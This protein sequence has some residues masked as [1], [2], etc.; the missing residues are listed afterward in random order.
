[1]A[2]ITQRSEDY[3]KWYQELVIKSGLAEPSDVRGCMII[4]P[5]GFAIWEKIKDFLDRRF[6]ETGHQNAYFPIF[7]PKSFFSKEAKHVEGFAKEVAVV[8]HYRLKNSSDGKGVIVDPDARLEEEYIVR[9]TSETIIWNTYRNWIQ[10]YR[11]LPILINQWANV[12]RWEMRTRLFLRTSEFL[13]Q[14]GHTAHETADEALAEARQMLDIY[15]E[16][17]ENLLAVPVIT[18]RKSPSERF[19]GAVETFTIEG[20]MQD[21]K[22]LQM[23]TSHFLG[24]NFAK[25]FDVKFLTREGKQEFVW[26]TSWGVST[27]LIGALIMTHSDDNGLVLPPKIAPLQVV[28]IPIYKKSQQLEQIKDYVQP[29]IKGLREKGITVKFDNDN[30]KTPGW[31]FNEYELKGVPVRLAIGPRDMEKRTVELARRD[32][33][34]K[35]SYPVDNIVV[36]IETL[37][38]QM[39]RDIFNR[40]LEYRKKNTF[41]VDTWQEFEQRINQGGFVVAHWDGTAETE[42]RIK[43]L[44][45]ATIRVLPLDE[46]KEKGKDP[47]TGK[48]SERRVLF[49]R[50]Y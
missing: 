18:G 32:N 7:I 23:G 50:A 41:F 44:T 17:A 47:L 49:A 25:A 39:Q 22:A 13:W 2:T 11:D 8:T 36:I 33:L 34:K 16:F 48:D 3:S 45:K 28:I 19:A 27:R 1:M 31:K 26:A 20:L 12:V 43:E 15:R 40:A 37:L 21:G 35:F 24:Q 4:K 38:E 30:N 46:I 42:A 10:S 29:I 9:P 6:K 5:Y 14:E